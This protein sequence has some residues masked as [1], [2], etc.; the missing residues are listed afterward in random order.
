MVHHFQASVKYNYILVGTIFDTFKV[1]S[2]VFVLWGVWKVLVRYEE[3]RP[4]KEDRNRLSLPTGVGVILWTLAFY[5]YCLLFALSFVWLSFADL[6]V[7]NAIAEGRNGFDVAFTTL[8]FCTTILTV[9]WAFVQLQIPRPKCPKD[10]VENWSVGAYRVCTSSS[11]H[12]FL[13]II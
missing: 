1:F 12:I 9:I 10:G 7:I 4:K 8:Q 5:Q 13:L 11:K 3:L 2:D 6:G